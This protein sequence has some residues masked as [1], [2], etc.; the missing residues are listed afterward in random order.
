MA[1]ATSTAAV[2]AALLTPRTHE[3]VLVAFYRRVKPAGWWRNTA[4][5]AGATPSAPLRRLKQGILAVSICAMSLFLTLYGFAALL[6]RS[7]VRPPLL[8]VVAMLTGLGIIPIW[9][10]MLHR[11]SAPGAQSG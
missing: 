6:I 3:D 9:W 2:A 11:P 8:P 4:R 5:V 1:V 10:R 7:P